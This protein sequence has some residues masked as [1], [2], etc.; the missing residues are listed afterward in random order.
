VH[1]LSGGLREPLREAHGEGHICDLRGPKI[2]QPA[3]RAT[4]LLREF[5]PG[6]T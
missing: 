2:S 5:S 1:E 4:D 3:W 6:Q